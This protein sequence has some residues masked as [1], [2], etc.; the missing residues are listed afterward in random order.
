MSGRT[1]RMALSMP[2]SLHHEMKQ[3]AAHLTSKNRVRA[4]L[5][6][7]YQTAVLDLVKRLEAGETVAF[8]SNPHGVARHIS[9]RFMPEVSERIDS[10]A[11]HAHR[12][13][14]VSTSAR[15]FLEKGQT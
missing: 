15:H 7:C 4:S 3:Y 12:S 8:V 2:G 13:S 14:F 10:Y 1:V 9:L 11:H 5:C 6:D